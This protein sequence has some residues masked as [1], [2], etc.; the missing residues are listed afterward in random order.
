M[1]G[2]LFHIVP[3]IECRQLTVSTV[4]ILTCPALF[5]LVHILCSVTIKAPHISHETV[6]H[7]ATLSFHSVCERRTRNH[8]RG[9]Y[10]NNIMVTRTCN[11][12]LS[13]VVNTQA[14]VNSV[15]NTQALVN[16]VVNTEALANSL[17][18]ILYN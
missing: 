4:I 17:Q 10:K 12:Q 16:S 13:A 1:I 14:K 15:V 7:T 8:Q 6:L 2:L 18:C 3:F 11:V 5:C 9:Y